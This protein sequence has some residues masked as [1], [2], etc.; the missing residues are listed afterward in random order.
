M[1]S[2]YVIGLMSGTSLDGVD[3]CYVKFKY[4]DNWL[5]KMKRCETKKYDKYWYKKLSTA[6]LK[7][8]KEIQNINIEYSIFLSEIVNDFIKKT[9]ESTY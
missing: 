3:I 6:Y 1:K 5:F 7:G 9:A 8:D 4:H 2:Y